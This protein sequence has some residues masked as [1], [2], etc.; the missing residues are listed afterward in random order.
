MAELLAIQQDFAAALRDAGAAPRTERWLAGDAA[1]VARR[2]AIYRANVAASAAK[3]LAAAYPIVRQIVGDDFFDGLARAYLRATPSTSG[4]LTEYGADFS[5]F[6]AEFP[7]TR[8]M[9]YLPDVAR[10]EWAVHRAHGAADA[11][12]PDAAALAA[13][14]PERQGQ[15]RFDWAPGTAVIE[16]V[17]PLGRV[18]ALH[19]PGYAGEFGVDWS[20]A[21][22]VLVARAGFA[23]GVTVLGRGDAAFLARALAGGALEAATTAALEADPA[24]DLGALLARAMGTALICGFTLTPDDGSP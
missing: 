9:P 1:L 3:A 11:A 10:L 19:Q 6:V 14:A 21:E 24:F 7:H 22:P 5:R 2:L 13:V 8:S 17:Y 16:S 15:I 20:A 4:D 23:V 18:W 12:A